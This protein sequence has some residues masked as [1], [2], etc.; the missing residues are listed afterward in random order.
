MND[1]SDDAISETLEQ[2]KQEVMMYG[3]SEK[4]MDYPV[5]EKAIK[6]VKK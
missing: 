5:S 1:N 3:I 4:E 6:M 2:L